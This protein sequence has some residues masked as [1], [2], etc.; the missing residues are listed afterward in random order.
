[1]TVSP[2]TEVV[3][4]ELQALLAKAGGSYVKAYEK[5]VEQEASK[6]LELAPR[7][8]V[9]TRKAA[10][11]TAL[12]RKDRK[13][14]REAYDKFRGYVAKARDN[15]KI[16]EQE[17]SVLATDEAEALMRQFLDL[18][19]IEKMVKADREAIKARVFASMTE[20]LASKG[21]EHPEHVNTDIDL[22]NVGFRFAREGAGRKDPEINILLLQSILG[23][24]L[25][26]QVTTK[27]VT[28][29][30]SVDLD[31][32]MGLAADPASPITLEHIRKSLSVGDWKSPSLTARPLK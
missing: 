21:E 12:A 32:L 23:E 30:H 4:T 1:M 5:L 18:R 29:T 9:A 25:F 7:T 22:P 24:D 15:A 26:N 14:L 10:W 20:Y 28:V 8:D 2:S 6:E 27:K 11:R 13:T 17:P 31:R 16:I 19:D 3:E